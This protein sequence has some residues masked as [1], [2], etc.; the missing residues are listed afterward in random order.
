MRLVPLIVVLAMVCPAYGQSEARARPY[1]VP[2]EDV[3]PPPPMVESGVALEPPPVPL[4]PEATRKVEETNIPGQ[5]KAER[6]TPRHGHPYVV[7]DRRPD[8]QFP[9]QD[10]LDVGV[11]V[12][13]WILLEF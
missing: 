4:Q 2:L 7:I 9:K 13:Q 5:L 8:G 10:N 6:V 11:R 12:P 1:T 3:P